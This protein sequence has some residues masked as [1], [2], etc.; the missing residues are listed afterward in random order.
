MPPKWTPPDPEDLIQRYLAGESANALAKRYGVSRGAV[1]HFLDRAGIPRRG[2]AEAN[3]LLAAQR[4]PEERK[5]YAEAANAACRGKPQSFEHRCKIA[6]AKERSQAH[7]SPDEL[8]LQEW[9]R[10]RGIEAT[11]Q[12]A[13][14]PYNA[15]LAAY[16]VAVEIF[17][18]NWHAYGRH[19]TRFPER[20]RYFLN[21]SWNLV[22]VW[23]MDR[24][25]WQG[26][27]PLT[28]AAADY[29]ASFVDQTRRD[30]SI[31]GQYRVIWGDGKEAAIDGL[32]L[33][34]LALVP[35]RRRA[36]RLRT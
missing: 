1:E 8:L 10:Q 6:L 13:I 11:L 4:T 17:G 9:L 23:V 35:S 31:R 2:P 33:H 18:G 25:R 22:I 27:I 16:P 32:E 15:D 26:A 34:E 29:I 36:Y 7:V 19:A 14:G 5:R 30:P 12:K 21:Q 28:P 24:R 20:A 3:R